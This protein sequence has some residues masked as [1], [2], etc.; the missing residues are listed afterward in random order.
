MGFLLQERTVVALGF[1]LLLIF[2]LGFSRHSDVSGVPDRYFWKMKVSW[3]DCADLVITGDSR[4]L[5][6]VS[7]GEMERWLP[8]TRVLNYSFGHV[9][10]TEPYLRA[11]ENVL[12]RK[13]SRKGVILCISPLSLTKGAA[14]QNEFVY[15]RE[16]LAK[17]KYM[18]PHLARLF[19]FLRPLA[20]NVEH[21]EGGKASRGPIRYSQAYRADGWIATDRTPR[22]EAAAVAGYSTVFG[23]ERDG[24]VS[25]DIVDSV[26]RTVAAWRQKAIE[27]YGFRAP[28]CP[29]VL[30]LENTRGGFDE[31]AF[32]D[33]FTRAGGIWLDL[34]PGSFRTY[35]GS[36]LCPEAAVRLSRELGQRIRA[37][38]AKEKQEVS[39]SA[40]LGAPDAAQ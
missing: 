31:K 12:A 7:P 30:G 25:P 13:S 22:N 20:S 19:H 40:D 8:N 3:R 10:Y 23:P 26:V 15:R 5:R 28:A 11:A 39:S 35:D 9:G 2:G 14:D 21:E 33:K 18:N 24:P 29:E 37:V 34:D 32:V 16:L 36:H 38:R 4:A 6:A 27:V 1:S 17:E